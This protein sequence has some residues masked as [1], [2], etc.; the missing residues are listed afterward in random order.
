[1]K[2]ILMISLWVVFVA[3]LILV[4]SFASRSHAKRICSKLEISIDRKNPDLFIKEEDVSKL[5]SD[6]GRNPVG[7]ELSQIDVSALENLVLSHPAVESCEAF[8]SVG[9]DMSIAIKQRRAI[10]RMINVGNESFYFDSRGMLMP[11][12]EEFTS[13]VVLVNGYFTENYG[14]FYH[15]EFDSY[16]LDSA[17]HTPNLLDDIWQITKRI[18]A[19]TFLR[20]QIVQVYV[21]PGKTFELIP[22]VGDHKIV[23]GD[24]SDLDE[25]FKKLLIFYSD[26]LNRTGSW[27]DY[28]VIDLQ[29]K[30]Q[31]VCTKKIKENGI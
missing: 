7:Q 30:N 29:Y 3:G 5:L 12:S 27:T 24:I 25:K 18:D 8:I 31:I 2:K 19:D 26:G 15:T 17:M 4:M 13:P 20:A 16:S 10:S 21:T 14:A 28:S 11:W 23:L 9:G 22:R 6:H 1:M